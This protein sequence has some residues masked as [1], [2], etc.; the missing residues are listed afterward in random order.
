MIQVWWQ[1]VYILQDKVLLSCLIALHCLEV[2][3]PTGRLQDLLNV[4]SLT[5]RETHLSSWNKTTCLC[6]TLPPDII[7]QRWHFFSWPSSKLYKW[8][9]SCWHQ[10]NARCAGT[11]RSV[12][13]SLVMTGHSLTVKMTWQLFAPGRCT[14]LCFSRCSVDWPARGLLFCYTFM[15]SVYFIFTR[16]LSQREKNPL[17]SSQIWKCG[18]SSLLRWAVFRHHAALDTYEWWSPWVFGYTTFFHIIIFAKTKTEIYYW[19][20]CAVRFIGTDTILLLT[21]N[22][23]MLA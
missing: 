20:L 6:L 9:S 2:C 11:C 21:P 23:C 16:P 1:E 19:R 4:Y 13:T 18:A 12:R 5:P 22:S 7:P 8:K 10:H 15:C 14:L 17:N 3:I